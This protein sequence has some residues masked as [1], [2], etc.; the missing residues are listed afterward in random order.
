MRRTVVFRMPYLVKGGLQQTRFTARV[1]E[2]D[3]DGTLR[4]RAAGQLSYVYANSGLL[5][6]SGT[7]RDVD[8]G[9]QRVGACGVTSV[10]DLEVGFRIE[11]PASFPLYAELGE[12]PNLPGERLVGWPNP[13]AFVRDPDGRFVLLRNATSQLRLPVVPGTGGGKVTLKVFA[14]V[15]LGSGTVLRELEHIT[16]R[17]VPPGSAVALASDAQ[18]L[19]AKLILPVRTLESVSG[20]AS[21]PDEDPIAVPAPLEFCAF[22]NGRVTVTSGT[23]SVAASDIVI[24]PDGDF[25]VSAVSETLPSLAKTTH[26]TLRTLVPPGDPTPS[27][28]GLRGHRPTSPRRWTTHL[29]G[30]GPTIS[31]PER[32]APPR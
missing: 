8:G 22:G 9:E 20:E 19:R 25:T 23:Q 31:S 10:S 26:G 30:Y 4:N 15:P 11:N 16:L 32:S 7:R 28:P 27:R 14:R 13:G 12:K 24:H 5:N 21:H 6:L 17:L 1:M 3:A 18:V 2:T 29:D